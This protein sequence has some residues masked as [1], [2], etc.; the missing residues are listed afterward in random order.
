MSIPFP[1]V[2]S[3]GNNKVGPE[4]IQEAMG[5]APPDTLCPEVT[6]PSSQ[7]CGEMETCRG[8]EQLSTYLCLQ[9]PLA[10]LVLSTA[11]R[12]LASQCRDFGKIVNPRKLTCPSL[13]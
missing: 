1:N 3:G 8:A 5:P 2:H 9:T 6:E 10:C 11:L 4:K 13:E 12:G 7:V